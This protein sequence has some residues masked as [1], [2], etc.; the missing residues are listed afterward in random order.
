M[1]AP[2]LVD[3]MVSFESSVSHDVSRHTLPGRVLLANSIII[4]SGIYCY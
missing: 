4:S 1:Q 3:V 2:L